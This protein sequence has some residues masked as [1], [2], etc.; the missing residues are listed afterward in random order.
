MITKFLQKLGLKHK[1]DWFTYE[2]QVMAF[3]MSEGT[4]QGQP[5]PLKVCKETLKCI[6]DRNDRYRV[7]PS[8]SAEHRVSDILRYGYDTIQADGVGVKFAPHTIYKVTWKKI[9][10]DV[11]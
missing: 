4:A 6:V 8:W 3:I 5:R 10:N 9:E 1:P 2:F 7:D 11:A